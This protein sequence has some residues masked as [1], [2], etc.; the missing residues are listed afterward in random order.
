MTLPHLICGNKLLQIAHRQPILTHRQVLAQSRVN[1]YARTFS[2]EQE[3]NKRI[4][5]ESIIAQSQRNELQTLTARTT[6]LKTSAEHTGI[7]LAV[8]SVALVGF[9]LLKNH[10][11]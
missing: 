8:T 10:Q 6:T 5:A 1:S 3:L 11:M 2:E 4:H 9:I 7:F